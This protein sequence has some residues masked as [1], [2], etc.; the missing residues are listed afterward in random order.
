MNPDPISRSGRAPLQRAF[1]KAVNGPRAGRLAVALILALLSACA[2]PTPVPTA[3]PEP[4]V[5]AGDFE[6]SLMVGGLDREYVVHIPAGLTRSQPVPVVFAFHGYTQERSYMQTQ[7][8]FDEIADAN[9]LVVIYPNGINNSWNAGLCCGTAAADQVDEQAFVRAI[10]ADVGTIV[11]VDPKRIYASG[12][13]NGAMLSFHLAC[14]MSDTFAAIG[15]MSGAMISNPCQ[16]PDPVSVIMVHGVGDEYVP[17][18]GGV[19]KRVT[20]AMAGAWPSVADSLGTWV[21]L[22]ACTGEPQLEHS[23]V[24]GILTITRTSHATCQ[25][26]TAVELHTLEPF[27]HDWPYDYV[28]PVAQVMW[29]FFAAHPKE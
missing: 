8:G 2:A 18:E 16:P 20:G 5:E 24:H 6:R 15:S 4:T 29:S 3:T 13:S 12:F 27:G 17:Y 11:T 22:N 23:D 9:G 28:V 10:L 19:I 14:T 7:T 21:Q 25:A 1:A 26:G